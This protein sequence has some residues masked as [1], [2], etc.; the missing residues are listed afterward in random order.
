MCGTGSVNPVWLEIVIISSFPLIAMISN[1]LFVKFTTFNNH[2]KKLF[3]IVSIGASI[4]WIIISILWW[5][6]SLGTFYG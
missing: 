3:L 1:F 4:L 6:S 2:V 5:F